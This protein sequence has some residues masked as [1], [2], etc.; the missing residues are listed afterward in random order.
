MGEGVYS[1]IILHIIT[2]RIMQR[3]LCVMVGMRELGMRWNFPCQSLNME[4]WECGDI[5]CVM[6]E[7]RIWYRDFSAFLSEYSHPHFLRKEN[8]E[9][10]G[11]GR[12]ILLWK[13]ADWTALKAEANKF[14]VDLLILATLGSIN[15]NWLPNSKISQ[16]KQ[17]RGMYHIK[18]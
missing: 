2:W 1:R 13:W 9:I 5:L 12:N 18:F 11:A 10:W 7:M 6:A 17:L 15:E 16:S 8:A 3:I 4:N 14:Y